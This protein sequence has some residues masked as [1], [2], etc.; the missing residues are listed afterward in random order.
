[1][2]NFISD[3][4]GVI[5]KQLRYANLRGADL[6]GANLRGADLC[7]ADL[8]EADL[9]GANLRG[10]DL[11]GANLR[12]ADL[13]EADLREADLRRANLRGADLCGANLRGANLRGADLRGADLCGADLRGA[14]NLLWG[15]Q[16]S[17]GY[18]FYLTNTDEGWL[19]KAGCRS[20]S[21]KEYRKHVNTYND[22]D[23]E[24]E[25]TLLLDN[26]EA[27]LNRY[28]EKEGKQ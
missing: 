10:A 11:C 28:I 18:Q 12:G 4:I 1:M 21:I 6:C 25:T 22:E 15:G 23:K 14:K 7:G 13:R 19:V 17:D 20:M 9:C 3:L 16:R 8:R 24:F 27:R 26:L 5:T 2:N